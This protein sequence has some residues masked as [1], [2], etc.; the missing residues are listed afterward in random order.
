MHVPVQSRSVTRR[1]ATPHRILASAE[2]LFADFGAPV[3]D[4]LGSRDDCIAHV[5][6]SGTL[7][8]GEFFG[9]GSVGNGCGLEQMRLLSHGDVVELEVEGIGIL[10]SV[11][12][13]A[14]GRPDGLTR[15]RCPPRQT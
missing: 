10:A 7:F 15:E 8:P 9:S 2:Q 13:G 6:R 3:P 14:R 12:C 11:S 1:A 4:Y 5:S